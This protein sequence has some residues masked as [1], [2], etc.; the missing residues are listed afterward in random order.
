LVSA[1]ACALLLLGGA[2]LGSLEF[3]DYPRKEPGD[4]P[5]IL[6]LSLGAGAAWGV[7]L[8]FLCFL[9]W[10]VDPETLSG[11]LAQWLLGGSALELLVAI[12]MHMIVRRRGECSTGMATGFAIGLGIVV[13]LISL[14]PAVFFLCYR[15]YKQGYSGRR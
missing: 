13:M 1:V 8:V 15:R 2:T 5:L 11:R 12:P 10:S 14:G 4:A 6:V 7:W 9:S 3:W